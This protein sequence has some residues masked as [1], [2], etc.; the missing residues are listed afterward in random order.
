[1]N[2]RRRSLPFVGGE[3]T[4]EADELLVAQSEALGQARALASSGVP[5]TSRIDRLD[6]RPVKREEARVRRVVVRVR[7]DLV[8]QRAGVAISVCI[9]ASM[10]SLS[11]RT[12]VMSQWW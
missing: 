7:D 2:A 11:R 1:M 4:D 3:A 6:L 8:R 9:A 12:Q 5:I 10:A